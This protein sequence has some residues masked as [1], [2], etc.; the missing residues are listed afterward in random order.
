[1]SALTVKAKSRLTQAFADS[2]SKSY[3]AKFRIFVGFC[4]FASICMSPVSPLAILTF[5][6]FLTFNKISHSGL[7]NYLSAVKS[8][9]SSLGSDTSAFN[10][11]RIK[12]Y[13]KAIMRH[14]PLN[15]SIKPIID[16]SLLKAITEQ[17]ERMYMGPI[18]KAAILLSFFSF[19]R[20]SNLVPHAISDYDPLKQLSRGDIIFAPPGIHMIIKWSKTLQSK[21]NI[22]VLKLPALGKSPLCPVSAIK[23]VLSI[24]TGSNN[25]PLFKVKCYS[26]WVPLTDTRLRKTFSQILAKVHTSP[27][28]VTFHSL[29]RSGATLAF[30]LNV[31]MQDIQS[32]GTWTSEAVWTYITQDHNASSSVASSF[33][34]LLHT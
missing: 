1:M 15:P 14:R 18:F 20:I 16:I 19:V 13:N 23:K 2:T 32:H 12:L 7:L 33:E 31:P 22:K 26:K 9:L 10:D 28:G 25:S 24:T 29:R 5:L 27:S 21:D 34:H 17:A 30:N 3:Q 6:E 11:P 4:C 8:T